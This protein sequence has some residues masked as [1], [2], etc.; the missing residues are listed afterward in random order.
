M[1]RMKAVIDTNVFIGACLG[2]GACRWVIAAC[3]EEKLTPLMEVTLL[4]EYEDVLGRD[5]LFT[6]S[7]LDVAERSELLDM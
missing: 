1:F 3:L 7:R 6:R 4:S 5:E 2:H